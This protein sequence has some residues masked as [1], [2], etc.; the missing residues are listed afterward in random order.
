MK[1]IFF[2]FIFLAILS[3][4]LTFFGLF[5]RGSVV[6]RDNRTDDRG[7]T[8]HLIPYK[9][10]VQYDKK[11]LFKELS[12]IEYFITQEAGS[13][14][15]EVG[16]YS[17]H[18]DEGKYNCLICNKHLFSSEHKIKS[19]GYAAFSEPSE[20]VV[21]LTDYDSKLMKIYYVL[22]ENC[23]SRIGHTFKHLI[24]SEK[25]KYYIHSP[26]LTFEPK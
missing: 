10:I 15:P 18:W 7:Y 8:P 20:N 16:K 12:E 1:K 24:D 5:R 17:N 2:F 19:F 22:C 6:G 21:L 9:P 25:N 11:K 4:T 13:E 3:P 14:Y 26:A 23:G